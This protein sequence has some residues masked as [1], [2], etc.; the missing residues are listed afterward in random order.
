MTS[1]TPINRLIHIMEALRNEQTG[2][3]WDKVQTNETLAHYTIEEAYEVFEA[4]KNNDLLALK[5]ELGD[6]LFQVVFYAQISKE[7]DGFD[8][9]DIATSI[10]NKMVKRHPHVFN[11]NEERDLADQT[12][13]W[14]NQKALER[15]EK[16]RKSGALDGVALALPALLRAQKIQQR[17]AR[18][19]F[20]WAEIDPVFDKIT[21]EINEVKEALTNPDTDLHLRQEIG[22]LLFSCVNLARHCG[23]DAEEALMIGNDKFQRRFEEIEQHL[24]S[25]GKKI[26]ECSL[27]ELEEH[28]VGVKSKERSN[29]N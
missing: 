15:T 1:K 24:E 16:N 17:A 10:S 26:E 14:E 13:A 9:D 12:I 11:Q 18:T 23:V 6:L 8:F 19:G 4:I 7:Q 3:P 21:E 22:D 25:I 28:W 2:C 5:D 27:D 20:D 29:V